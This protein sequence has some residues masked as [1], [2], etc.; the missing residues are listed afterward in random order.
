MRI[1]LY[2]QAFLNQCLPYCTFSMDILELFIY[3]WF[4]CVKT[5]TNSHK[6][7]NAQFGESYC[8]SHSK[9]VGPSGKKNLGTKF[10][11]D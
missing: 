9:I 11:K 5:A 10:A 6:E 7:N 3:F 8:R 2:S 1:G 4:L